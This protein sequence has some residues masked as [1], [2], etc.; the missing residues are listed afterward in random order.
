PGDFSARLIDWHLR[1]GRHDLPWQASRDPYRI[2]LSEVMLQQTQVATVIPYYARFLAR[3]PEVGALAAAP[4]EEVMALWSGL[5]YYARARNLHRAARKVAEEYG[6]RFPATAAALA[7]LPG[8]GRSTAAAI[9][10][11]ASDE[12]AAILDGNVK[13]VL[14][15]AF[16]VEGFPGERAVE[17]RLW[18]LAE[19]LLPARPAE[20]GP[21]IQAQMDLGAT[22]CTRARPACGRCPL[23]ASCVAHASGRV[24]ELP[25]RR[26]R[27]TP[28]RRH[29]RVA[30]IVHDNSA[31]LER[32][33]P[34]GIWG[35]LLAL[36]EIPPDADIRAWAARALGCKGVD[37]R[38]L[39][40]L[41]HGFTHFTLEIS[42]WRIDLPALPRVLAE[43]A[44]LWLRLGD[45][46][47]AALPAPVRRILESLTE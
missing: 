36:P 25:A 41:V 24:A 27:K 18:A 20:I 42:P 23:A 39:P 29:S 9:A 14:C 4:V 44:W 5:G 28:P 26:A 2:W 15:R 45:I 35:G 17:E 31:L 11:F 30:V 7:D 40:P 37:A 33:P 6:G 1:H 38:E 22:V 8:V 34:A 43:P 3:F 46:A 47:A 16:G 21:Y 32:R 12:R 13:R 19:S 10:A